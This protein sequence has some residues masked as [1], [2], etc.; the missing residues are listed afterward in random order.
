MNVIIALIVIFVIVLIIVFG[1]FL[2]NKENFR[3]TSED[4]KQ[5][6]C[7]RMTSQSAND[8]IGL[9]LNYDNHVNFTFPESK[10][11]YDGYYN[12][13]STPFD[14]KIKDPRNFNNQRGIYQSYIDNEDPRNISILP[15][16][17]PHMTVFQ[18]KL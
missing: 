6:P 2:I 5:F 10:F 15:S 14:I 13:T 12:W 7:H 1:P 11:N 3:G 9:E 8:E 17:V 16:S 4:C 18:Q